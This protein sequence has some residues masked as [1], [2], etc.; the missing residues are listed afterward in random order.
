MKPGH[1]SRRASRL[2]AALNTVLGDA[3]RALHLLQAPALTR[4]V[5]ELGLALHPH[6][7]LFRSLA[8]GPRAASGLDPAECR[9]PGG[10]YWLYLCRPPQV[11]PRVS[12]C[13]IVR[14]A[15]ET[16]LATL[17]SLEA[18]VDE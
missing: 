3:V 17:R 9:A 14:N 18:V 15:A 16:L 4:A 2:G 1:P 12:L 7:Q 11:R 8:Q 10:A 5:A 6:D 13:M